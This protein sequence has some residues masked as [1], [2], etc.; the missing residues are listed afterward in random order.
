M[1]QTPAPANAAGN[2]YGITL[3]TVTTP[4]GADIELQ[5]SEEADWYE[6]RRDRY[7]KDNSFPN[8]SDLQ[9]LDRLL[10]LEILTHRWSLWLAR[11]F[12]Y[13]SA[14]VDEGQLKNN[15][16]EYC[17]SEDVEALTPEG[18]CTVHD[19]RPGTPILA[20]DAET[21]LTEWQVPTSVY[22]GKASSQMLSLESRAHSSLST[23][24]HRWLV[25]Q[26]RRSGQSWEWRTSAEL[27]TQSV[28]PIAARFGQFEV[29]PKYS[30]ALV[31][32]IA[33]YWTEGHCTR[34][35]AV[36]TQGEIGQSVRVNAEK[37]RRI[38]AAFRVEFGDPAA[39]GERLGYRRAPYWRIE[40]KGDMALFKFG[41]EV[42]GLLE[43]YAPD[44]VPAPEFYMHLTSAQ[45][46]THIET[47][48]DADGHRTPAGT[49]YL[50]QR[51]RRRAEVFQMLCLL[52]GREAFLRLD[53]H[54]MWMVTVSSSTRAVKPLYAATTG[55]GAIAEWVDYDGIVWC[56]SVP[57]GAWVARRNGKPFI[58]GNSVETRLLKLA[59][60]IDK[61]TRDKEKGESL[62]DYTAQLLQR[63]KEFG[64]H[65]N[66]QYE[67]V[68][69]KFYELRAMIMTFD[70]CDEE[71]RAHLDLSHETIFEWIRDRVIKDFDEH[72]EAFRKQQAI[73]VKDV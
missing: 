69:T 72:S 59:L 52:D 30:D 51:D 10:M 13:M 23:R 37:V 55:K 2:P 31:E 1:T 44:R 66:E 58:T 25:R 34:V 18:W 73:W 29:L 17:L 50:A 57:S 28:I 21:G 22:T 3:Y 38:E 14:R 71:E 12:D 65:R 47:A 62:A 70:R 39:A 68:V 6:G 16:K 60:G 15:I 35:K 61:A 33:W 67:L 49:I 19:L 20:F 41:V 11:G 36:P 24:D 42:L 45:L 54:D 5:T 53:G 56:P 48:I 7:Q 40:R 26:D 8:I 27:N 43:Y 32:L 4:A 9:D 46:R 63:A 64:Y